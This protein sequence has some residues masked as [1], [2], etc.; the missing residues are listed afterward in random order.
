MAVFERKVNR[1][2][3]VRHPPGP[4]NP[5]PTQLRPARITAVGLGTNVTC[6]VLHA[7]GETYVDLPQWS[8]ATPNVTGWVRT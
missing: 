7:A 2:V 3:A 5:N 1:L 8:R 4:V 6:K